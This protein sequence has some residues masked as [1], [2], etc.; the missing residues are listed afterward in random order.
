MM[1]MMIIIIIIISTVSDILGSLNS[2]HCI[3]QGTKT[4]KVV[5]RN[6]ET[7]G[8]PAESGRTPHNIT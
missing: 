3:L 2:L 5:I 1:M 7:V 4:Q 6:T 8:L